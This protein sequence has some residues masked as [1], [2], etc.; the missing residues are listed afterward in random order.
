MR[1]DLRVLLVV[2]RDRLRTQGLQK[3]CMT[4]PLGWC[5]RRQ[6]A[7]DLQE[8][9][10]EAEERLS[11]AQRSAQQHAQVWPRQPLAFSPSL[12]Y[13]VHAARHTFRAPAQVVGNCETKPPVMAVTM[14]C[15]RLDCLVWLKEDSLLGVFWGDIPIP[16]QDGQA[17]TRCRRWRGG[18][19]RS[20]RRRWTAHRRRRR[21][22]RPRWRAWSPPSRPTARPA[23]RVRT[24]PAHLVR[25]VQGDASGEQSLSFEGGMTGL[26]SIFMAASQSQPS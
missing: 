19:R 10:A 11:A 25:F 1:A 14:N 2:R 13:H 20:M 3:G 21:R 26:Q 22:R 24:E 16:L 6:H 7:C 17:T 18:W 12:C 23:C 5:C 15:L 8:L 4:T 9:A